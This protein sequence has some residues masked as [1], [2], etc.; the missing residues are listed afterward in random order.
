M[1]EPTLYN[2][3]AHDA[4]DASDIPLPA[5]SKE[6]P[7]KDHALYNEVAHDGSTRPRHT[8]VHVC[9]EVPPSES[10]PNLK[11]TTS[12]YSSLLYSM[13]DF[14]T[15]EEVDAWIA[16]KGEDLTPRPGRGRLSEENVDR[17]QEEAI[18]GRVYSN[19]TKTLKGALSE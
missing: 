6:P 13:P 17:D 18:Q 10:E 19:S 3:V 8:V 14:E 15:D 2:K 5:A 1:L 7:V 9:N 12:S 4:S 11:S 16:R